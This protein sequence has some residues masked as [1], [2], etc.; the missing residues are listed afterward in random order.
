VAGADY[1]RRLAATRAA[2]EQAGLDALLVASQHN[3][4]YLTGFSPEDG[5]ITESSGWALVTRDG[6]HLITGTFSLISLEH[7]IVASGAEVLLT[8]TQPA[9]LVL[10]EAAAR[11]G[12]RRLGFERDWLSYGRWERIRKALGQETELA[13]SD[14]LV[15]HVRAR[16]DEAEVA[17][18]R[19]AAEIADAAFERLTTEMRPGMTERQVAARLEDLMRAMGADGPSFATIVACGPGGALPHAVP[20]ERELREGEPL[21]IDF[22]ARA[23]GYCSDFTRTICLGEPTP[24]LVEVY[25]AVRAAQDAAEQALRVGERRGSAVDAAARGVVVSAG[26]GE[27]FLHSLGHGVGMAVHE[28]PLLPWPRSD[29]A[30]TRARIAR[31]EVIEDG[32]VVTVEPGIYLEGWGG[33]RLEDMAVVRRGAIDLLGGR[34]PERILQVMAR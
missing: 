8:D 6:L 25:A 23:S 7:E 16:K 12:L 19:R 34:N 32:A 33:V 27:A 3:R 11:H 17:A 14:D 26:Y 1:A 22:G 4:R 9:Q 15:E 5:D 10:A 13:P 21:L 24:K 31:D 28:L 20:T 30:D 2:M 18:I 29:D